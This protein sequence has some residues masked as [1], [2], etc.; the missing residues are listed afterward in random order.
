[1][2]GGLFGDLPAAKLASKSHNDDSDEKATES[3]TGTAESAVA[4]S[5]NLHKQQLRI[6][7]KSSIVKSIGV[8][9]TALSF[10]P[11]AMLQRQRN[12][13]RPASVVSQPKQH[14]P[15][16]TTKTHVE[17]DTKLEFE[18][19]NKAD[20]FTK[21]AD[22]TTIYKTPASDD[23][24]RSLVPDNDNTERRM[25]LQQQVLDD[26]Y[27]P[28]LPNDLL[29]Y[30]ERKAVAVQRQALE[31]ERLKTRVEQEAL[32]HQLKR[33]HAEWTQPGAANQDILNAEQ[34]QHI[35]SRGRG[36][37]LTNLPAWLVQQQKRQEQG[38]AS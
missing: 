27:D 23:L 10:V 12:K 19:N 20:L 2:Y 3:S 16:T 37:G 5:S 29:L 25:R 7:E 17:I 36:R 38:G 15:L 22:T 21:V 1:M 24:D 31:E 28:L 4:V 26:P 18:R 6:E 8:A 32:R 11:T 14:Q 9:G 13:K 33:E 35:V 34:Q 30:W